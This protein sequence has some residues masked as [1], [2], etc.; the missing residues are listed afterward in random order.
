M[1]GV[2]AST[3][4]SSRASFQEST[5]AESSHSCAWDSGFFA[6]SLLL[7]FVILQEIIFR[8]R[9]NWRCHTRLSSIQVRISRALL[10]KAWALSSGT[11]AGA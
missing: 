8:A 11:C 1:V 5:R 2:G 3:L 10:Q 4:Y 9:R 7:L 6:L